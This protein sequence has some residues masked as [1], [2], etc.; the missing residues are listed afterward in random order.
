MRYNQEYDLSSEDSGACSGLSSH[1][2]YIFRDVESKKFDF[3]AVVNKIKAR[4]AKRGASKLASPLNASL[5]TIG[6]VQHFG[7]NNPS[8][9]VFIFVS[10]NHIV[11]FVLQH[12]L[13][14]VILLS[15]VSTVRPNCGMVNV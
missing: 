10:F 15:D 11:M 4:D 9:Y 13:M 3:H 8:V 14:R 6:N 1:S 5:K 2:A 12:M 7:R